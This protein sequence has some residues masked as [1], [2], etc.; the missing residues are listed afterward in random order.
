MAL[1]RRAVAC[2]DLNE[3]AHRGLARSLARTGDRA[4]ALRQVDELE[5][6]LRTELDAAP[7]PETVE[8]RSRLACHFPKLV[9]S[10]RT[11]RSWSRWA[12]WA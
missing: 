11:W 10:G 12:R 8:L 4:A 9:T 1:Y 5:G 2:D 3:R 6:L 7:S